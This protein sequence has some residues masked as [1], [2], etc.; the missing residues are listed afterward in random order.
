MNKRILFLSILIFL[1]PFQGYSQ[2]NI[3]HVVTDQAYWYPYTYSQGD[4]AK[5]IH[6]EMVQKALT[7][8]KYKVQFYPKPW[9]RCLNDIKEGKYDA[10]V[11]ASFKPERAKYLFY[12][13]DA[14]ISEKSLWR[15]TQVE[16]VAITNVDSSYTFNG[17]VKTLPLPVRVPLGYSIVDDLK[18]EG[19]LAVESPD[20]TDCAI[21]LIKSGRGAFITPSQNAIHIQRDDQFKEKLTIHPKPIKSKSYFMG[22]AIK[23]QKLTQEEVLAI[24]NEIAQIREDQGYMEALF[25]KFKGQKIT[26]KN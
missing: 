19:I 7:N 14:V 26:N 15:I 2:P 4:E 20:T 9:K 22:F 11:S 18:A 16:Y 21:Q 1:I 24:W 3:I 13:D 23:N 6:I 5:G 8:L 25:N 12:P 17:D 10:I